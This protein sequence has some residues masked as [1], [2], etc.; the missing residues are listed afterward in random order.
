MHQKQLNSSFLSGYLFPTAWFLA[1]VLGLSGCSTDSNLRPPDYEA[2]NQRAPAS[3]FEQKIEKTF[4]PNDQIDNVHLASQADY[5]FTL[6]ESYSLMGAS[7]KATKSFQTALIFKPNSLTIRVRLAKEY[8]KSGF[9]TEALEQVEQVNDKNPNYIP[10]LMMSGSIYTATQD[11]PKAISQYEKVTKLQ[12]KNIDASLYLGALYADL[13]EPKKA[14]QCFENV[15][16]NNDGSTQDHLIYY[17]IGR[18]YAEN[19]SA[20]NDNLAEKS[21]R[22]AIQLKPDFA[23]ATL[24]LANLY[25]GKKSDEKAL[26][27][28]RQYQQDFGTTSRVSETLVSYFIEHDRKKEAYEQ[29]L[30]LENQSEDPLAIKVKLAFYLIEFKDYQAAAQKLEEAINIAPDS[31]KLQFYL[32]ATYEEIQRYDLARKYYSLIPEFS[33]HYADAIVRSSY[34]LKK[35][36]KADQA[37]GELEAALS[38]GAHSP[39]IYGVLAGLLDTKKEFQKAKGLLEQAVSKFPANVDLRFLLGSVVDR[40]SDHENALNHMT[41]VLEKNPDHTQALNFVAYSF[42]EKGIRLGE[43]EK[44]AQRALQGSPTDGYIVDTLG[45]VQF[46]QGH[47]HKALTT[48]LK[49]RSLAPNESIVIEHLAEVYIKLNQTSEGALLLKE[50]LTMEKDPERR[51]ALEN[52][53]QELPKIVNSLHSLPNG[54]KPASE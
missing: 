12:P 53:L 11:Y 17:Y 26:D 13:D 16:K 18:V 4:T 8:L 44:M 52:K 37:I 14:V 7:E 25:F 15:L 54:R 5:Y 19:D 23:D 46:K 41:W 48:L 24:S 47:F 39:Q 31:D 51:L 3:V 42:A 43:A 28:L 32:G 50:A 27:I 6:G 45:W 1:A 38:K 22:K 33:S 35:Q 20:K 40:M 29:L 9:I 34:I 21:Y 2:T 49:A 36:D 10:G 30:I